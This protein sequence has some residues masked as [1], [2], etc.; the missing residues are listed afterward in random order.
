[1]RKIIGL[2]AAIW[3]AALLSL[4]SAH[5]DPVKR[6]VII[7]DEG[8][9]LMHLTLLESS[10]VD[11]IGITTV[12][13]NT[14]ANRATA[15]ALRGLEI[16]HRPD[17]PVV[18]GATYPLL[19]S[20]ALTERWESLYGKLTWKGAWMKKWVESTVQSA[21]VYYGPNDPVELP[22]GNPKLKA[23]PEIA[24]NFMIRMVHQYP[25]QI[26][27]VACGPLTNLALAQRLDPQFASLVGEL[28]YMGGSFNPHQVLDNV[29]AAEFAREYANSPRREF[30]ARFD[31]EA[32]SIVSRSPWH[33]LTIIPADPSTATQLT[34]DLLARLARA[35]APDIGKFIAAMEPGYPLWDEIAAGY[36]LD[37]TIETKSEDLYVDYDTQFGPSYGDTLS[38]REHYQ[39]HL[40]EQKAHVVRAI[41]PKRL[42]ALMVQAMVE[43]ARSTK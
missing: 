37:P 22:N 20:E 21:P 31:P 18:Q 11:V 17:I 14:W 23:S 39:P 19:N 3:F 15:M 30:N 6:K 33:K 34:P 41:D 8:F 43:G 24:A 9:A 16:A 40:G 25:G 2:L 29:S 42:A 12:S 35:A 27:I 13:G 38:W 5:A 32:A 36:V 7:D 1:M 4:G 28:V 26:T 10:K